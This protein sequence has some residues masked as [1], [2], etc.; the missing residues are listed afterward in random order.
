MYSTIFEAKGQGGKLSWYD[1]ALQSGLL[2]NLVINAEN[3]YNLSNGVGVVMQ[4]VISK[5]KQHARAAT[6]GCSDALTA[7]HYKT[8]YN[9]YYPVGKRGKQSID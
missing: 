9:F 3:P 4:Q 6:E 5:I 2:Q 1:Q 8:L 7:S